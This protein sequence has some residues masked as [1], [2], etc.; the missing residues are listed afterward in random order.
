MFRL[1]KLLIITLS[2]VEILLPQ[3]NTAYQNGVVVS[4][5]ANASQ[6]G[7]DIMRAGGNAIDAA[8]ATGFALAVVH[9]R[10]GNIGGGGFLVARLA[11][12][13]VITLDFREKAPAQAY[14][15]M[16]QDTSGNV[17]KNLSLYTH[18]AVAV[19]GTVDGLLRI[20][21]DYGSG[22]V[23]LQD[24]LL[25][26]IK[27][28]EKGFFLSTRMAESLNSK[29]SLFLND[30]GSSEIFIRGDK[31]PWVAGQLL[32]QRDLAN[33]LRLIAQHGR[34]GFYGGQTA[35]HIL[36]EM[37]SN[38]GLF[39]AADLAQYSSIYREPVKGT[40]NNYDIFTM[41]LPSSGGVILIEMLNMLE[42]FKLDSIAWNSS[43]YIHILTEIARRA[44]A[45]RAEYLGD[46]DFWD[47]PTDIL[48]DKN[49][50]RARAADIDLHKAIGSQDIST[51]TLQYE[52]NETTHYSAV[53]RR[54]NCVAVTTTLNTGFGSG[55]TVDGAG[56][57]LNNEM[58]DFSVKPGVPNYY[59]LI[60][61]KANAVAP[62]KRPLSSM[63][64]TIIFQDE[65]P[66]LLLGTPGGSTIMTTVL[67]V[68]LNMALHKMSLN[69]AISAPRVHSQWLPDQIMQEPEAI[70]PLVE[71]ELI[72]LG[73]EIIIHPWTTFGQANCILI[74]S[75]GYYGGADPRGD[76]AVAGY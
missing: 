75:K 6:I 16:Y 67:Q 43:P 19:P 57:L 39:T 73:H 26:A 32:I 71:T 18:Q 8:V 36:A 76:N 40:F 69:D 60:G 5:N 44:Y 64:P 33:T 30:K 70:S 27:I 46:P 24:I 1:L 23:S 62:G 37:Q 63:T 17:I 2:V 11:N 41:G 31:E 47:A 22:N 50:A 48:L 34:E 65:N 20:F 14:E 15:T 55:I 59:G 9:P 56:F 25:P 21:G 35:D 38:H 52:S 28:A 66:F 58:D 49:Y 7:V 42:N 74:G 61:N 10:A 53:D 3:D 4:A 12:G 45:D 68:F 51:G 54:G 13:A 29:S 72:D